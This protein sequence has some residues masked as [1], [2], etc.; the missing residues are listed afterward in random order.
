MNIPEIL[1]TKHCPKCGNHEGCELLVDEEPFGIWYV[2][3]T[4][5]DMDHGGILLC[6]HQFQDK[7]F[8]NKS[9]ISN[10]KDPTDNQKIEFPKIIN[11]GLEIDEWVNICP[12]CGSK[13]AI[14][15]M[16]IWRHNPELDESD[17]MGCNECYSSNSPNP[18]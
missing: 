1:Y 4:I 17:F 15:C 14:Y 9:W 3:K 13:L 18:E 10:D 2:C 16:S 11:D 5:I 8:I 6:N 7:D 12:G